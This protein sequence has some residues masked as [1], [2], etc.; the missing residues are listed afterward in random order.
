MTR[1]DFIM[2]KFSPEFQ[3][4]SP[5]QVSVDLFSGLRPSGLWT[6]RQAGAPK[7]RAEGFQ[8]LLVAGELVR[9]AAENDDDVVS[10]FQGWMQI[11]QRFA[12]QPFAAVALVRFADL[13]AGNDGIAVGNRVVRMRENANDN[14][15]LGKC[16]ASGPGVAD[17]PVFA[18]AEGAVHGVWAIGNGQ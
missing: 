4:W 15:A 6:S 12:H 3:V 10:L 8:G 2:L 9:A 7:K 13:L 16:L 18:K 17:L 11:A 14:R 1:T 5:V